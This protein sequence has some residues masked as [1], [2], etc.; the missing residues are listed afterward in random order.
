MSLPKE[1]LVTL[2]SSSAFSC[3]NTSSTVPSKQTLLVAPLSATFLDKFLTP[4][5]H[6]FYL[7]KQW[8]YARH[9][10]LD[11]LDFGDDG[12]LPTLQRVVGRRGIGVWKVCANEK[13]KTK[14]EAGT[15]WKVPGL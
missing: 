1:E 12:V 3:K 13:A 4:S 7:D 14:E 9:L 5:S 8:D 15:K 11:D 2:L 6:A 10:N